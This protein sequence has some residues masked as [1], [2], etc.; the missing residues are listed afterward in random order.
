MARKSLIGMIKSAKSETEDDIAEKLKQD[1]IYTNE[2]LIDDYTPSKTMSPSSMQCCRSMSFKLAGFPT[3]NVK[4]SMVLNTICTIGSAVHEYLQETCLSLNKFEYLNVA[5]YIRSHEELNL[6]IGRESD[7]ENKEFETHLYALDENNKRYISFLCDGLIKD[8]STG[9][10]YIIEFK[11]IGGSQ[12]FKLDG[13]LSKHH[14]QAIAYSML[15]NIP[16]VIFVYISRDLPNIKCYNY[17]VTKEERSELK[18]KI[19]LVY[20]SVKNNIIL[21]KD[22]VDKNICAYCDYRKTCSKIGEG[23]Y[24]YESN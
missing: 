16:T 10:L 3:D 18:K 21:P 2:H 22:N 5:E 13:V 7:F 23:E 20:N 4:S 1:I 19:D 6:E 12:F 14:N 17:R 8:K 15:L 9:K 24:K 11:T